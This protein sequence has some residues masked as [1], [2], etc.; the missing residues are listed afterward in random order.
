MPRRNVA[1]GDVFEVPTPRGLAYAQYSH[2]NDEMGALVRV[3]PG[4]YPSRPTD[5]Q[6]VVDQQEQYSTFFPLQA[7]VRQGIFQIVGHAEVPPGARKF[8]LFRSIGGVTEK[9]QPLNWW[10]W[11]GKKARFIGDKLTEEQMRLPPKIV[12]TDVSL[13]NRLTRGWKPEADFESKEEPQHGTESSEAI[14][15]LRHFLNFPDETNARGVASDL[16]RDGL[17]VT[18]GPG[19]GESDWLVVVQQ[20]PGTEASEVSRVRSQLERIASK[21]R[22]EYDGWEMRASDAHN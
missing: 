17:E 16:Q 2:W 19:A 12:M 11:D 7:A 14:G 22:G 21:H 18:V 13:I 6:A 4:F 9:G 1:V 3:L 20:A 5:L 8:P 10:L 15:G